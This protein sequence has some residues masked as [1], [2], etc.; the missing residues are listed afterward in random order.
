MRNPLPSPTRARLRADDGIAMIVAMFTLMV[1]TLLMIVAVAVAVQTAGSA[2][3]DTSLKSAQEAAAAGLQVANYRLNMLVP[4][5]SNCVGD[6]VAAPG[7]NGTCA[8]SSYMLG[9][10]STYSYYT[11]PAL[12]SGA[13]CAGSSLSSSIEI[14]QRCITAVGTAAGV[15]AR[16]QIR[17]AAFAAEPLFPSPGITGLK[18]V[19]LNGNPLVEGS[20]A[21]NV[22]VNAVGNASMLGVV[23]GPAGTFTKNGNVTAPTPVVLSSPL[24]LDPV[25]PGTSNQS[26]LANCPARAAAGYP[27]CNDDYRITNG[28]SSPAVSPYD[29]SAGISW[30][31]TTR[32]LRMT[33]NSS[34]TLGGG[35]YN[36][37]SF[38]AAGNAAISLAPGVSAEIFIDSPDDP[39]SGCPA[40]SGTFSLAGK[41]TWTNPSS[42]PT[43]LQIYAYGL[44]DGSNVFTFVGNAAFYGVI[45]A[46]QS[47][48]NI[49]GNGSLTG[50]VSAS[51]VTLNGNAFNWSSSAGS[52]QAATLG[53][54]YQTAWTACTPAPTQANV[55]GS[56][57]GAPG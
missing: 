24:V 19:G 3:R 6:G 7:S 57:C 50:A 12:G 10:G 25:N 21:S 33:G 32:S 41:A 37:C 9:N 56:G 45:Y 17:V 27:A 14:A 43:S 30:D 46:P 42:N 13:V 22:N 31:P 40:G 34:L 5:S 8:S 49:S 47:T 29:Q 53:T 26:S 28:V 2:R 16:A 36:F 48:V 35:L 18:A 51:N 39:G 38:S 4:S 1:V 20:V 44:N 55:P 15:T 54:Y 23:L 11:T 52:L